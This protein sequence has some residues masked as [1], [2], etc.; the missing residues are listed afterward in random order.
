MPHFNYFND[1]YV[2]EPDFREEKKNDGKAS[3]MYD[4]LNINLHNKHQTMNIVTREFL[5]KYI[6]YAKA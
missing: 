5:K 4:K 1:D 6:S 3:S 2:I